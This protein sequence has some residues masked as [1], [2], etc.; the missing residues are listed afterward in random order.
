[1]TPFF[2]NEDSDRRM[3][4]P[5]TAWQEGERQRSVIY[6]RN[7]KGKKTNYVVCMRNMNP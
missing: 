4:Q 5:H 2:A 3:P 7:I 1:M 6:K